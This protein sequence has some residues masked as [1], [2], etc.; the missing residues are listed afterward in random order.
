MGNASLGR[1]SRR[2]RQKMIVCVGLAEHIHTKKDTL[3]SGILLKTK[4]IFLWLS[5]K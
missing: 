2:L 4:R 1:N 5:A 3:R